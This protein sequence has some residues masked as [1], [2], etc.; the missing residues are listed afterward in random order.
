MKRQTVRNRILFALFSIAVLSLIGIM[1]QVV[2][3]KANTELPLYIT[4]VYN[5]DTELVGEKIDTEKLQVQAVYE[6]GST[7][8]IFDYSLSTERVMKEG[9]NEISVVYLGRRTSFAVNGKKVSSISAY[10]MGEDVS[11]GNSVSKNNIFVYAYYTDGSSARVT[12]FAVGSAV[13]MGVGIN[14]V[15]VIYGGKT[16]PVDVNGRVSGVVS[17]I[18]VTYTGPEVMLGSPINKEDLYVTALYTDG[19]SETIVNY[20]LSKDTPDMIGVN[21]VV[22]TYKHCTASFAV[23]GYERGVEKLTARYVG[24][25]VEI[26]QDVRKADVLVTATYTDGTV[27][28]VKDFD[29]PTPTIYFVGAHIKTVHYMGHTADIYVIG[30]E[31]MPVSFANASE[32]TVSNGEQSA[33]CRI[34]IPS[35]V[36][37]SVITGVSLRKPQ[38]S[39]VVP[40]AI[41]RSDFIPFEITA[42][43]EGEDELPLLM[44][45]TVPEGFDPDDCALYFTPNRKTIIARMNSFVNEDGELEVT[46][47]K[48]GTFLLAYEP[49]PDEEE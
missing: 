38:V 47:Y 8:D 9:R 2:R 23:T 46:I 42:E 16:V 29:L 19:S 48:T 11:V 32:F 5:G 17:S 4:A 22:V 13:I 25:G 41:R 37:P 49:E 10:Y 26:G 18:L 6:D 30:I 15:H 36:D 39:Q 35:G 43:T 12:N 31:A 7:V 14:K 20:E 40:R 21:T 44:K 28:E 24:A 3:A 33:E 34:A 45:I 1:P 27:E